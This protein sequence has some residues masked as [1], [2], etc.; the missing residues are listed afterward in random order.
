MAVLDCRPVTLLD[1][2]AGP[3]AHD[4]L[5]RLRRDAPVTRV[6]ELDGWL[7]TGYD[8]AV[9]VMRDAAA[10]TVD[11][12]RFSTARVVGPSMLSLDGREHTRHRSPFVAAFRPRHVED[13]FGAWTASLAGDLVEGIRGAGHAD[14]R[15]ALA[16]PLAVAVVAFALGLDDAD[17][18]TVLGWYAAIVA[19]VSALSAGEQPG[20]AADVAVRALADRVGRGGRAGSVL[21]EARRVLDGA[22]VIANAAVMMFGGIETTEGMILNAV[23]HLLGNPDVL[24]ALRADPALLPAVVEESLR[25]EPAAAAV[26]RYATTDVE[27]AGT[28]I[29]RGELVRV[30]ITAANRD[31]AVFPDP[32]RFDPARANVR[33]QLS[34]ARGPHVCIAMDLARLETRAALHAVLDLPG[35]RLD[36]PAPVT[37]LIFRKPP[38]LPV[39]W[40]VL[41]R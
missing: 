31:P 24:A 17:A 7:V 1:E 36:A 5:A 30:S 28:P 37:G 41:R 6:A 15:P 23:R 9:T 34:F 19:A 12:P 4:L 22:D 11:D 32:D 13:R 14:L 20:P 40:D 18:P 39:S 33:S 10:F 21:A 8:A 38:T 29:R 25:L 16:G 2:L 35:L 3:D 26:D 27:L